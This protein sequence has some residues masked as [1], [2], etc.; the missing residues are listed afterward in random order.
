MTAVWMALALPPYTTVCLAHAHSTAR[1][2]ARAGGK[3][4]HLQGANGGLLERWR[5]QPVRGGAALALERRAGELLVQVYCVLR[6]S[7]AQL[8]Q[9]YVAITTLTVHVR[10]GH[11]D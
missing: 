2:R 5:R 8:R 1:H 3:G 11:C 7:P 9:V 4:G 6:R 10:D